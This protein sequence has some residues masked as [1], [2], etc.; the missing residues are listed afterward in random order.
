M[1]INVDADFPEKLQYIFKP[2]RYKVAYGGRGGTKSWGFARALIAYAVMGK[3]RILCTR[4]YQN[5]IKESVHRL[6][7]D[8]IELMGLSEFFTIQTQSITGLNGSEFIFAGLKTDPAKIKSTEGITKC[9]VEEAEKVSEESWEKLIPT[10]RTPG[11]EIWVTFN[12]DL[13]TDP[14]YKRFVLAP[15]PGAVVQEINWT[16]NPWFPEELKVEKD[17]LASVDPEAYA[18]VWLGHCRERSE[19]QILRGKYIIQ[20]FEPDITWSGP[21]FGA[22]W[23][24]ASDPTTLVKCWILGDDLYVEY[25][26]WGIGVDID[27]IPGQFDKVPGSR[28]H[29]IRADS[30]R[31]ETISYLKNNGYPKI[32]GVK[33]GAG[34]V[35]EGISRLRSFRQIIIHPRC[36][37]TAE[38]ALLWSYKVD[39]LTG[40]VLPE[41]IKKHDH[42]WDGVRY[43]IQPLTVNR[44]WGRPL[45]AG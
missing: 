9:W 31:P 12:P 1:Q 29:V 35:D 2:G 34:S 3:E 33:K 11:S 26:F 18:H 10:I 30:A 15:P 24:F 39:R 16:D 17:Y 40:D 25:E 5:S 8:Q 45:N 42:C 23:G 14:T 21:Y 32:E 22:D 37:H 28:D 13:R 7:S 36:S 4:E 43:A 27:K 44:P 41:P 6:L 20:D 19:A 38:E